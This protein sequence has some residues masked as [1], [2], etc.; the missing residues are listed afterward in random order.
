MKASEIVISIERLK[1]RWTV[2]KPRTYTHNHT[3]TVIQGGDGP[4][5][6][7]LLYIRCSILKR[8][9]LQWKAFDFLYKL[10]HILWVVALLEVCDVTRYDRHASWILS[11]IRDEIKK[12][13]NVYFASFY[14]QALLL[15][16]K[17]VGKHTSSLKNGWTT[18]YLWPHASWP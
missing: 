15:F 2:I 8:F 14:P 17:E 4:S 16:Q 18:C 13:T 1:C 10:R 3:P 7:R 9:S 6:L 11:R 5:P 12:N